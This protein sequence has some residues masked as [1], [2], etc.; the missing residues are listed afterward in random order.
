MELIEKPK[1]VERNVIFFSRNEIESSHTK[2]SKKLNL[3][4][5]PIDIKGCFRFNLSVW[6]N[7]T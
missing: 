5:I 2:N 7:L 3:W 1:P 4:D 6:L